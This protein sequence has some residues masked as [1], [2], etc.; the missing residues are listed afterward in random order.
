MRALLGR[1][2]GELG[3]PNRERSLSHLQ[4]HNRPRCPLAVATCGLHAAPVQLGCG[5]VRAEASHLAIEHRQDQLGKVVRRRRAGFS[6]PG[7]QPPKLRRDRGSRRLGARIAELDPAS[8]SSRER[9]LA[10]SRHRASLLLTFQRLAKNGF[11][12]VA[13]NLHDL[14]RYRPQRD[15]QHM[16]IVV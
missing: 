11:S 6:A 13:E 15:L 9:R 4:I 12:L 8:A 5:G 14:G 2:P 1:A 10:A 16:H 7:R 3:L